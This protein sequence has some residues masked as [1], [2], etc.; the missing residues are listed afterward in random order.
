MSAPSPRSAGSN[1]LLKWGAAGSGL[2]MLAGLGAFAYASNVAAGRASGG[3]AITVTLRDNRCEPGE[4]RVPEGRS[5]FRIV[6][7]TDRAVEWEILDG[8]MVLEERENIAPGLSQTL[9]AKLRPGEYEITCGLLSNPRGKLIVTPSQAGQDGEAERPA[10]TAFIGPLAEYQVYLALQ[11]NKLVREVGALNDAIQAG[12]LEK[13]RALYTPARAPYDTLTPVMPHLSDLANAIDPLPAYLAG[14]EK[15]PGFT[16]FHKLEHGLFAAQ[17]L[18]GLAPVSAKLLADV[19]ALRGRLRALRLKPEDMGDGAA[20]ALRVM[21]DALSSGGT[22][23][24]AGTDLADIEARLAG[25]AKIIALLKPVAG[26][27][28]PAPLAAV[29]AKLA[30]VEGQLSAL[31][32]PGGDPAFD[33]LSQTQKIAL[34]DG[35][36]ALEQ[37]METLNEKVGFG[38]DN[39]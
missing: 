25:V 35:V 37:A 12:D 19:E 1:R 33:A 22:E 29:E 9:G 14:R 13:A 5:T 28:A 24:Y 8:V 27:A 18:D 16:G 38:Q 26:E 31:R 6:N 23:L 32:K 10:L 34:S 17:S 39:V 15:D 21:A 3:G 7:Q 30:A 11:S 20:R 4:L 2:L 36:N